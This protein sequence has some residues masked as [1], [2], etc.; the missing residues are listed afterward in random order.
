MIGKI[1]L[2]HFKSFRK[3]FSSMPLV[4]KKEIKETRLNSLLKFLNERNRSPFNF[5]H[6]NYIMF[7]FIALLYYYYYYT[8]YYFYVYCTIH[9]NSTSGFPLD[10]DIHEYLQ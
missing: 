10:S 1:E 4:Q 8:Y 2:P 6:L 5:S 9:H 3:H 7:S